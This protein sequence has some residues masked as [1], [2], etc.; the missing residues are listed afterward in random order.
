MSRINIKIK[1]HKSLQWNLLMT[2]YTIDFWRQNKFNEEKKY[3]KWQSLC[4]QNVVGKGPVIVTVEPNW[5][6]IPLWNGSTGLQTFEVGRWTTML[7]DSMMMMMQLKFVV[8]EKYKI[9]S[10]QTAYWNIVGS[11]FPQEK[12][13]TRKLNTKNLR[14]LGW[15][16]TTSFHNMLSV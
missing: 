9:L 16:C 12:I 5:L 13:E 10:K 15:K 8:T 3:V 14:Q 11:C 6:W 2:I 4:T 7:N 1:Q